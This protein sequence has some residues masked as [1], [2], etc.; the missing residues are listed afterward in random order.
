MYAEEKNL[1]ALDGKCLILFFFHSA[2]FNCF[3]ILH[4]TEVV[5]HI[6]NSP[7]TCIFQNLVL[8]AVNVMISQKYLIYLD[9]LVSVTQGNC[10]SASFEAS[11]S[12]AVCLDCT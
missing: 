3:E 10:P 6:S 4:I 9:N 12:Q 11:Q 8:N 7:N 5:R 1:T 2:T